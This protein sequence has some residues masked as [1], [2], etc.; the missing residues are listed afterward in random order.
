MTQPS[1]P[2]VHRV[3]GRRRGR[4]LRQHRR[5]LLETLLP[6]LEIVTPGEATAKPCLTARRLFDGAVEDCWLEIGFGA[7]EHLAEQARAHPDIGFIGCEPYVNGVASLLSHIE[8]NAL[9]NI[10]VLA[11]DARLILGHLPDA[12]IGR[13]FLLFPDPWPKKRH[14]KRRFLCSDTLDGLARVLKPGAQLRLATD[15]PDYVRAAL[16]IIARRS[17]FEWRARGPG[18]WRQRPDDWPATR[19]EA[20][21]LAAGRKC[22]Y[23]TFRRSPDK[24]GSDRASRGQAVKRTCG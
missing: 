13:A 21:A 19:Y 11:D 24:P 12:G 15:S 14:A 22:Y 2:K 18:D 16:E 6:R 1:A 10:R 4:P 9:S 5:H 3:H 20:K 7:G 23:L 8:K 17:D